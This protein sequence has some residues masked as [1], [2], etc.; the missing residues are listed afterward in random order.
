MRSIQASV[1]RDLIGRLGGPLV[2]PTGTEQRCSKVV[3]CGQ[4]I[5][6]GL[7]KNADVFPLCLQPLPV[8]ARV[9]R[10]P[11]AQRRHRCAGLAPEPA[12]RSEF[13]CT[14]VVQVPD[15]AAARLGGQAQMDIYARGSRVPVARLE[16]DVPQHD[17]GLDDNVVSERIDFR[18]QDLNVPETAPP[19]ACR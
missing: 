5:E 19:E 11:V 4:R 13:Q 9:S 3:D 1:A 6:P 15:H 17:A 18:T 7:G 8:A 14:A 12:E 16:L 2:D 10:D